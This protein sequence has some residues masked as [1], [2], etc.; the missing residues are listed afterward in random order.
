VADDTVVEPG[1]EH[2]G[3]VYDYEEFPDPPR[4]RWVLRTMLV[5]LVALLVAGALGARWVERRLH[6][7]GPAG[8]EVAVTIPPGTSTGGIGSLLERQ[9]VIADA[10]VFR[11]YVR[12]LGAGPFQ[13]GDFTIEKRSDMKRV[14]DVLE[15]G[16]EVRRDRITIPEGSTLEQIAERVGRLPGR[17]AETFRQVAVSGQVRSQFQPM[18]SNNLEGLLFPDTYFVTDE[19]DEMVILMRM[20][21]RFDDVANELGYAGAPEAVGRPPYEAVI[22]ASMIEREAKVQEDRG[23]I[24]RVIY[25]RLQADMLLQIDATL[26]YGL[27]GDRERLLNSDL[28]SESPYN[29]YRFKGLPPTPIAS[30][31]RAALQAAIAPEMGPWLF[32]VLADEEG[33][34]AFAVTPEEFERLRRQ[35]QEK[36]LL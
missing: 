29:T 2:R 1:D 7:R 27:G 12:L 22:I 34:H 18:G 16:P 5:L 36:G 3:D 33:R 14:V 8:P 19:D 15:R 9:G 35:A 17:S 30:P 10:T 4:R 31:G 6:P 13:A 32:Y 20:V 24:S 11:W 28:Q 26:I 21:Q 25:N 23:K